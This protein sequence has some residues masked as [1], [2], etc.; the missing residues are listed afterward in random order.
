MKITESQLNNRNMI[1]VKTKFFQM[2]ILIVGFGNSCLG[3]K[4]DIYGIWKVTKCISDNPAEP[5]I[6]DEERR[7]EIGKMLIITPDRIMISFKNFSDTCNNPALIENDIVPNAYFK[8][9]IK[10]RD[11]LGFS[12]VGKIELWKS[13]CDGYLF[14]QFYRPKPDLVIMRAEG[15]YY[16]FER[17][18]SFTADFLHSSIFHRDVN[19]QGNSTTFENNDSA[20]AILAE[21]A[22]YLK[23]SKSNI[24]IITGNTDNAVSDLKTPTTVDGKNSTFKDLLFARADLVARVLIEKFGASREQVVTKLGGTGLKHSTSIDILAN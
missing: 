19:F 8:D 3:Q 10:E 2:A 24:A 17:Q 7:R 15:F 6:S 18:R 5:Q 21:I 1:R 22:Q 14:K 9:D 4:S 11:W 13:T 23:K 20:L 16:Y 12:G